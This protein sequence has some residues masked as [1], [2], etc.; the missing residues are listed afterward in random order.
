MPPTDTADLLALLVFTP[1]RASWFALNAF[2]WVREMS[3][4]VIP[5]FFA[6]TSSSAAVTILSRSFF[7]FFIRA[8][9][10]GAG[11]P[12]STAAGTTAGTTP[13]T[14]ADTGAAATDPGARLMASRPRPA[15]PT[16]RLFLMATP[17]GAPDAA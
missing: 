16:N 5:D 10:S 6:A 9:R 2:S 11:S 13:P 3:G 4:A 15:R 14:S 17:N 8:A 1:L 12:A 7:A